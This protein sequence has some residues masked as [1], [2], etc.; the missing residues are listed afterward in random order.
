MR[1]AVIH[2]RVYLDDRNTPLISYYLSHGGADNRPQRERMKRLLI[3]A[4]KHELTDRQR[5]CLTMYYL[6]G[7]KMKDIARSL[8]LSNSTVSRH[9]SSASR[10][11]RRIAEYYE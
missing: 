2:E 5:E 10:K 6:D 1:P 3:R 9:I 11:L 4:I 7:M 8:G